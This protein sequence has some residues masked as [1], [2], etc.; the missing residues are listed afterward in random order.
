MNQISYLEA[1]L[2]QQR[3]S[4]V[5]PRDKSIEILELLAGVLEREYLRGYADGCK[6]GQEARDE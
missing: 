4:G 6:A 3:E 2:K 5:E 1:F